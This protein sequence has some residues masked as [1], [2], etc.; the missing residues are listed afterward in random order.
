MW[1][2]QSLRE[3]SHDVE[4][5]RVCQQCQFGE[6]IL[7]GKQ[8]LLPAEVYAYKECALAWKPRGFRLLL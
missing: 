7:E 2:L 6:G 5:R 4:A 1:M 8:M 3:L